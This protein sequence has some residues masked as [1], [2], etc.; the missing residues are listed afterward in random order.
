MQILVLRQSSSNFYVVHRTATAPDNGN[1]EAA[2]MAK[3]SV[4]PSRVGESELIWTCDG[5]L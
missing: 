4:S 2:S 5:L 1:E 3:L